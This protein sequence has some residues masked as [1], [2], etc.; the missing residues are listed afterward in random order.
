MLIKSK[1]VIGGIKCVYGGSS[2]IN[3]STFD[4]YRKMALYSD[5]V[6]IPDP[7]IPWLEVERKE[8]RFNLV[9]LL[10]SC[11]YLLKYKPLIDADL[12]YPAIIVFPSFEKSLEQRTA[13]S[14]R[15]SIT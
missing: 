3:Q 12:P 9:Y 4:S 2:R 13:H 10:Q 5:T 14:A 7:I 11:Y 6:F 8:E 1:D 15:T